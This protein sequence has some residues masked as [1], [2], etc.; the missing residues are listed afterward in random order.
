MGNAKTCSCQKPPPPIANRNILVRG[1]SNFEMRAPPITK[2]DIQTHM[3]I[4]ALDYKQTQN[5]LT[6]TMD[7]KNM[8]ELADACGVTDLEVM[9]DEQCTKRNVKSVI[10]RVSQNCYPDDYFVFYYSGHG[11]SMKDDDGDERDG[12][13]EAFCFVDAS[14]Q[15][16]WQSCLRDDDFAR[17]IVH[18]VPEE[19]KIIIMTDCCHS[20]T[21]ADLRKELWQDRQV[22]SI[23]GCLDDQT[24]GDM[25][26]GG[27]F[28]HSLLLA[29][30]SLI[31]AD[32][33]DFSVGKLYNATLQE[34]QNVFDSA[35]DI[36]L[37]H[38]SCTSP[39]QIAWPLVPPSS[40]QAPLGRATAAH[41][42]STHDLHQTD[43]DELAQSGVPDKLLQYLVAHQIG[44]PY[45]EELLDHFEQNDQCCA[46]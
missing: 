46:Q 39:D 11:T 9:F 24:S 41:G 25:G 2:S 14:G 40:Y 31:H 36:T 45:H 21:I 6:C 44:E 13:D 3:I 34:D 27:I 12:S 29:I 5:P 22:I 10:Q 26:R 37:Q 16:T 20:G 32:E 43:P 33:S 28:T 4:L 18:N 42:G 8:R 17:A 23:S 35:Q 19:T 30:D 15:I 7:G 1:M 38:T